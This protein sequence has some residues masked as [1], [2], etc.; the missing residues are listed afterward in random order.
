MEYNFKQFKTHT[1]LFF[2]I[3]NF[4]INKYLVLSIHLRTLIFIFRISCHQRVMTIY[5]FTISLLIFNCTVGPSMEEV[6][7]PS[8]RQLRMCTVQYNC[9]RISGFLDFVH[10]LVF[11]MHDSVSETRSVSILR[12]KERALPAKL[13]PLRDQW[14]IEWA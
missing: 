4:C 14:S 8:C 6:G 7:Q 13:G 10:H 3:N 12:W 2:Y 9:L 11:R 1:L 5:H